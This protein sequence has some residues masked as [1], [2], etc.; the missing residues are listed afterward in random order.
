MKQSKSNIDVLLHSCVHVS[1]YYNYVCSA[2]VRHLYCE[3]YLLMTR[4]DVYVVIFKKVSLFVSIFFMYSDV[5]K[6]K[7]KNKDDLLLK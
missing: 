6:K 1:L 5:N 7:K 2:D 3:L 4:E